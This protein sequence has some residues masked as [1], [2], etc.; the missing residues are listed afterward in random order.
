MPGETHE[1]EEMVRKFGELRF[2][3]PPEALTEK[4]RHEVQPGVKRLQDARRDISHA[5]DQLVRGA[6]LL[7]RQRRHLYATL[8]AH[9]FEAG[10]ATCACGYEL[11]E[12]MDA[13]AR[14]PAWVEHIVS[15][16]TGEA[17]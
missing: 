7:A 15:L 11:Y 10:A 13:V 3:R 17:I 6:G 12:V 4:E 1:Y 8:L 5:L 9:Y 14:Y 16:V 2:E